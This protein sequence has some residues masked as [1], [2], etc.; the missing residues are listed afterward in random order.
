MATATTDDERSATDHANADSLRR[1]IQLNIESLRE[2]KLVA[3]MLSAE[4]VASLLRD[5]ATERERFARELMEFAPPGNGLPAVGLRAHAD[6]D[7]SL[8]WWKEVRESAALGDSPALLCS[9]ERG[10]QALADVYDTVIDETTD[11]PV[12]QMLR[13]QRD[14]IDRGCERI[15]ELRAAVE[16]M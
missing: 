15:R 14:A 2:L 10:E 12:N 5:L 16:S 11:E 7:E 9:A 4:M 8:R 6:E 13:A 1:L 3:G